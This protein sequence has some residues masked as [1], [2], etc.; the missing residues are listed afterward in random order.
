MCHSIGLED[1]FALHN[2]ILKDNLDKHA[3]VKY[4]NN[5][6]HYSQKWF[7]DDLRAMKRRGDELWKE[8]QEGEDRCSMVR[9]KPV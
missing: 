1:N 2:K 8:V 6:S 3:P 7:N 4:Y 9:F 5:R